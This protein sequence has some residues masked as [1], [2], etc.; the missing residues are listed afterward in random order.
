MTVENL[1]KTYN[2]DEVSGMNR[3]L[4]KRSQRSDK[5]QF[6]ITAALLPGLGAM[7]SKVMSGKKVGPRD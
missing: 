4:Q 5:L 2:G 6:H 1:Y 3:K 7:L